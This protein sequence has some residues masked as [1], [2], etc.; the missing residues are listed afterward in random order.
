MAR[1]EDRERDNDREPDPPHS[2]LAGGWLPGSLA[3][4]RDAHQRGADSCAQELAVL[5]EDALLL[6]KSGLRWHRRQTAGSSVTR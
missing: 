6:R 3:E 2:H 5:V 1:R 4:R